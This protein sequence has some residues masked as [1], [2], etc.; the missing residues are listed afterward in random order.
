[1]G[2]NQGQDSIGMEGMAEKERELLM[3]LKGGYTSYRWVMT[4]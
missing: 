1:V 3:T 2:K 4:M